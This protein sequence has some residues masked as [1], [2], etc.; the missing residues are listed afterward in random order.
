[1]LQAYDKEG[2]KLPFALEKTD[3]VTDDG[4]PKI[5]EA[6]MATDFIK[7]NEAL[8][9]YGLD[10]LLFQLK[11]EL[12]NNTKTLAETEAYHKIVALFNAQQDKAIMTKQKTATKYRKVV[13]I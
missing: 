9:R 3:Y 12:G 8:K 6:K 11:V 7:T 13:K 10:K 2:R 1:M 5:D 4:K